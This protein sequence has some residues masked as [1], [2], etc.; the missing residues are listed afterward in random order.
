MQAL[1]DVV[2][3]NSAWA[4]EHG[5]ATAAVDDGRFNADLARAAIKHGK[6]CAKFIYNVLR[7]S[8]ADAAKAVGA[9]SR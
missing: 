6:L 8:G 3:G 1:P 5:L 4:Q 9:G 2:F 7:R